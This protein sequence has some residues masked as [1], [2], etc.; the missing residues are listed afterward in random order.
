MKRYYLQMVANHKE[1]RI[2]LSHSSGQC[3]LW[4]SSGRRDEE[5]FLGASKGENTVLILFQEIEL[6]K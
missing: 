3:C 5:S 1:A 2:R 6:Q 4:E